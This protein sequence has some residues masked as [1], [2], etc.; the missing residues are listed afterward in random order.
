MAGSLPGSGW[1]PPD[2]PADNTVPVDA[3]PPDSSA[4]M[5]DVITQA[6]GSTEAVDTAGAGDDG[7]EPPGGSAPVAEL[8]APAPAS[9]PAPA[10]SVVLPTNPS[11]QA[12]ASVAPAAG[13]ERSRAPTASVP[14]RSAAAVDPPSPRSGP[15]GPTDPAVERYQVV[16]GHFIEQQAAIALQAELASAGHPA[17]TQSRVTI[18]PFPALAE[19][20]RALDRLRAKH[21]LRGILVDAASGSGHAVQVGVFSE[22]GNAIRLINRL[23]AVGFTTRHD[24]RVLLGPY[25]ERQAADQAAA[26][27]RQGRSLETSVIRLR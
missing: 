23:E 9:A 16:V 1:A 17:L 20:E 8:P 22:A 11:R 5:P 18:G 7:S 4:M 21:A 6:E 3:S 26:I 27:V 15:T 2:D 12:G 24:R 19:A 10:P 14:D 25:S 13:A